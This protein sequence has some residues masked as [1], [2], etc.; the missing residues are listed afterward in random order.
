VL[1]V[2]NRESHETQICG[3]IDSSA[4][5]SAPLKHVNQDRVHELR[6]AWGRGLWWLCG[7]IDPP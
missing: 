3:S 1:N 5:A 4:E 7:G 6:D 2:K